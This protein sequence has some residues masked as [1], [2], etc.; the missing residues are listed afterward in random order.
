M[1]TILIYSSLLLFSLQLYSQSA[2]P[3]DK[4]NGTYYVLEAERGANTKIFE[5]GQHNNAK[6]LLIAA[7][8]QCIPGTYT[9]QKEASEE[10]QRAV[11]YN[12]TGLYVFQYD[13]ESFVMIMLNAS[14]DAEWTDFYF[15]NFYSKNKAK[16]KNM[17]KEK[18]KK[19]IL[20]ISG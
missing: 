6:L 12:S 14:E 7:C 17:S 11:F 9:Y 15:S 18:I 10:L 2:V 13:D 5:Y 16:V 20:K 1:K 4:I 8:K 19:F 3:T